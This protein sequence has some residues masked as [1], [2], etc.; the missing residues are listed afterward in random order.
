MSDRMR[1]LLEEA[2]PERVTL[3]YDIGRPTPRV[4]R[5]ELEGT[6]AYRLESDATDDRTRRRYEGEADPATLRELLSVLAATRIW[7]S[8]HV[9]KRA[10]G[11]AEARI[12]LRADGGEEA[13][14]VAWAGEVRKI[15]AFQDATNAI[16]Q[17]ISAL[18]GGEVKEPGR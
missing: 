2:P 1:M 4:T 11:E 17:V 16:L 18:S 8:E 10:P 3:V 7:E 12:A 14:V 5:L 9:R 13:A 15:P 6:G